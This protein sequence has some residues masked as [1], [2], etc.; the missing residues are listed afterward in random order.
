MK[1]VTIRI[2]FS[3]VNEGVAI[4]KMGINNAFLHVDLVEDVY[5]C[6]PPS[7]TDLVRPDHVCKLNQTIYGL[8]Q[9]PRA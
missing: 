6:E 7:F 9:A 1:L 5:M 3:F 2:V 8:T 4:V